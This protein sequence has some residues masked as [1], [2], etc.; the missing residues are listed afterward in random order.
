M[1]NSNASNDAIRISGDKT[2]A[3]WKELRVRLTKSAPQY[4]RADVR[5]T[6]EFFKLRL[7]TRFLRPIRRI[8]EMG[9]NLGEGMAAGALE[10]I[11]I[12]HLEATIQGKIYSEPRSEEENAALADKFQ[13]TVEVAERLTKPFRY[14]KSPVDFETQLN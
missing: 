4:A 5:E 10:C 11:L 13:V 9:E 12:E 8:L 6:F 3:D 7:E 14:P 2:I 1:S